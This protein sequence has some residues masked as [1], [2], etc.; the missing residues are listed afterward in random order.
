MENFGT[1][2]TI[3]LGWLLGLLTPGIAERIRRSYR[4]RDL[5]QAVVDEMLGLQYTMAVAAHQIRARRA[6]VSG[7]FLD[8]ILPIIE[9]YQGPYRDEELIQGLR[10]SRSLPEATRAEVHQSMRRPNVGILLRQYAIPLFVTQMADLAICSI[11]FQRSVLNIRYHLDLYNQTVVHAQSLFE[12][13][14]NKPSPE[15]REALIANQEAAYREAAQRIDII[16][17]AIGSL[18]KRN[19]G[20]RTPLPS[21]GHAFSEANSGKP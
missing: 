3:L 12:K 2:L 20:G 16:T 5:T 4:R 6:G 7:A 10:E 11:D 13:T 21:S 15:D 9:G 19:G 8:K 18:H 1:F 14:F 17:Q